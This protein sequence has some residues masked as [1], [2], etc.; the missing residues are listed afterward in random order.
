MKTRRILHD[1]HT[2]ADAATVTG[3]LDDVDTWASWTRPLLAHTTWSKWGN[4]APGGVGAVRQLGV[5]PV[6]IRE[7]ITSHQ[8]GQHQEYTVLSPDLFTDYLGRI[9]LRG[10]PDG[11][12]L[13]T[14]TVEFTP[15]WAALGLI[16][17]FALSRTIGRLAHRLACAA[18]EL[19]T[20]SP[21][22]ADPLPAQAIPS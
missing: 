21:S 20:A 7:L 4:P 16:A 12:T 14:W 1:A 2:H 10:Q 11:G 8:P 18:D 15:R 5:W 3:L 19:A 9:N 22:R 13:I 17:R 6:Y